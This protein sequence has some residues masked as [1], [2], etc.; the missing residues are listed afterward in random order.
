MEGESGAMMRR[1]DRCRRVDGAEATS[2]LSPA[3]QRHRRLRGNRAAMSKNGSPPS[4]ALSVSFSYH[5][6]LQVLLI[7]GRSW[8]QPLCPSLFSVCTP[9]YSAPFASVLITVCRFVPQ[10]IT[11]ALA[12]STSILP[13]VPSILGAPTPGA[14]TSASARPHS[15]P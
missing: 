9:F 1:V 7:A 12:D 14:A 5:L 2:G 15:H 6:R 11:T 10:V 8:C 4:H 13:N 3:L